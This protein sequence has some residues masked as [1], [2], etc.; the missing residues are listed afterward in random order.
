MPNQPHILI[1]DNDAFLRGVY[2]KALA[3]TGHRVSVASNVEEASKIAGSD[4]PDVVLCDMDMDK[5]RGL[6]LVQALR[7]SSRTQQTK[8]ACLAGRWE[9]DHITKAFTAGAHTCLVKG[10]HTSTEIVVKMQSMLA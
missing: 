3:N 1:A 8:V 7:E 6:E 5:G 9:K 2:A 10:H 4:T